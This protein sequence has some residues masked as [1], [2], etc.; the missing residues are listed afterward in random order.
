M[1]GFAHWLATSALA[2]FFCGLAV[3]TFAGA[4]LADRRAASLQ[5]GGRP[6]G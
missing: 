6:N 1:I 5:P 4:L 3:G 2:W